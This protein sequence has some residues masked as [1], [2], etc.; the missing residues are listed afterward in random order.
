MKKVE[1]IFLYLIEIKEEI[2][3]MIS[4]IFTL[5]NNDVRMQEEINELKEKN[6]M[7]EQGNKAMK[8]DIM[9]M[10]EILNELKKK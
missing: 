7:L 4:D 1:E 2:N 8:R 9:E 10:K 3:I 6:E 5:K